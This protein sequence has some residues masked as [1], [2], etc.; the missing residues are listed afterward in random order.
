MIQ[1][2]GGHTWAGGSMPDVKVVGGTGPQG[3][4]A[5]LAEFAVALSDPGALAEPIGPGGSV[6][7][8][9]RGRGLNSPEE[10]R[11]GSLVRKPKS[12]RA[13]RGS[14]VSG[15]GP[16]NPGGVHSPDPNP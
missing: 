7:G 2:T 11:R 10:E 13:A 12:G 15:Q 3:M 5:R 4:E 6:R 1:Q 14:G 8:S 16:V 9:P